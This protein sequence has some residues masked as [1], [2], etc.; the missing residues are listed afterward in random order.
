MKVTHLEQGKKNKR[1]MNVYLDGAFAF[2]CFA[3]V[4]SEL[5][6]RKG[7]ELT[8][9]DVEKAKNA[10]DIQGAREYAFGYAARGIKSEK[11]FRDKMREKRYLP[12]SVDAAIDA[13]KHYGYIDDAEYARMYASELSMKYGPWVIRRKLRERGIEEEVIAE[14]LED[15]DTEEALQMLLAAAL[16]KYSREEP[17]KRRD[18][19]AR[20]LASR[21][22]SFD[23]IN[24]ALRALQSED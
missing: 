6:I 2:A 4:A 12:T 15:T 11:Q 9:E 24:D 18:K 22:F 19:I 23:A 3:E 8:A 7:V 13:L 17:N 5:G 10:D 16:R 20:Y 1:R 14:V 21:G